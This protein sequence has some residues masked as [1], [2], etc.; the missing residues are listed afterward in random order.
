L[1]ADHPYAEDEA[2][3]RRGATT[4]GAAAAPDYYGL[5]GVDPAAS[6]EQVERAYRQCVSRI[7][8]DKYFN[9]A[10]RQTLAQAKLKQLNA[11]IRVLRDPEQRARYDLAVGVAASSMPL[12]ARLMAAAS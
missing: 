5:L 2:W 11:A 1:P 9:D 7:H 12:T 4:S 3:L 8:P 6:E 10:E